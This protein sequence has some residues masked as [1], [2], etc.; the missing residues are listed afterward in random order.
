[1]VFM[2]MGFEFEENGFE[3]KREQHEREGRERLGLR[4]A[5]KRERLAC[6]G[7]LCWGWP[8]LPII[9][10]QYHH[11]S[12][13]SMISTVPPW[14]TTSMPPT[15]KLIEPP[16]QKLI[17]PLTPLPPCWFETEEGRVFEFKEEG[18][19]RRES[20]KKERKGRERKIMK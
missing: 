9:G 1:M 12:Y 3:E 20:R 7:N 8:S 13:L 4:W 5:M 11:L 6:S 15:Q 2:C 14:P 19:G 10:T 18:V 17:E 16:P